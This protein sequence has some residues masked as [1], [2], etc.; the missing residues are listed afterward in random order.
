[1][2]RDLRELLARQGGEPTEHDVAEYVNALLRGTK[3]QVEQIM[4]LRFQCKGKLQ[5]L[6]PPP[7]GSARVLDDLPTAAEY[8]KSRSAAISQVSLPRLEIGK[9]S[10]PTWV[11]PVVIFLLMLI[12]GL[13]WFALTL[14]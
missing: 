7:Q 13:I 11:I 3:E 4:G 12:A 1:M 10:R 8:R 14:H 9:P 5:P 2:D 6:P